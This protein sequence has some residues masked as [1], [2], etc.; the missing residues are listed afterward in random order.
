MPSIPLRTLP[1]LALCLVLSTAPAVADGPSRRPFAKP[2][3]PRQTERIRSFDVQHIKGELALDP[4]KSEVRGTVT[5]TIAP[6]E[7]ALKTLRLDCGPRLVVEKV[8]VDGSDCKFEHKKNDLTITLGRPR[9]PGEAMKVAVTYKGSPRRGMYFVP[10]D[11]D[12]GLCVW[13]QGEPD[14]NRDWLPSYDYPNDRATSEMIVTAPKPLTVVSNGALVA[15]VEDGRTTTFHW[16]MDVPHPSY[17]ISLA[18]SDFAVYRD[19]YKTLPVEYY[20]A[21]TVDEAT[22]RRTLGKTPAMIAFFGAKLGVPYPYP[23]YAQVAV[24]EFTW[25]GMENISA[26]TLNDGA[27]F[28]AVEAR[29]RD[30][31]GLV[32]HELAHQWFGDLVTCKDWSHIW[33]NE[34]FATFFDAVYTE[35]DLGDDAYRL[36]LDGDRRGYI[37]SDRAYRRPIVEERYDDPLKLFD[38]VTYPKGACVLHMLRGLLGEDAFWAGIRRYLKDNREKVVATDDFHKAMEAA[39]GKDLDWYFDQWTKKAG[40]PELKARWRYESDDQ[41]VRVVVEQVQTLDDQTPLFR[42]PTTLELTDDD[43]AKSIPVVVD[44]AKEEFVIPA[45]KR[46]KLVRLDPKGWLLKTLDFERPVEEWVYQLEHAPEVLGRVEAAAALSKHKHDEAARKALLAAWSRESYHG[47][48]RMVLDSL[49]K[50][51]EPARPALLEAARDKDAR[52][53]SEAIA[54]LG[55]LKRDDAAEATLRAAWS[56]AEEAYGVRSAALRGLVKWGVKD[57]DDLLSA[58]LKTAAH[59]DTIAATALELLLD[60]SGPKARELAV[61]YSRPGHGAGLR[62]V[63]LNALDRLGADDAEIQDALIDLANDPSRNLR[64]RTWDILA[65][66]KV[67]RAIPVLEARLALEQEVVRD[68]L[69][70]AIATLKGTPKSPSES[71]ADDSRTIA[72]LD[73]QAAEAEVKAKELRLKADELRLKAEKAKLEAGRTK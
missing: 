49:A 62:F 16:K 35:H 55:E 23:K 2:G 19:S 36:K 8:T 54:R 34:G 13:T 63:A 60:E 64:S 21:R 12:H 65:R 58:G 11:A 22:A 44:G 28:D 37:A 72:D 32:A 7:P 48:R 39:S 24:P 66:S 67:R 57:K 26:T 46:P 29:E 38:G 4:D 61:R 5:H 71:A 50:F 43:G 47:A 17:L 59:R 45:A 33:L 56:D 25:G 6:L 40:H 41:T 52:V 27:F 69:D 31:D 51:G 15:T 3:T 30:A 42:L 10:A 14:E 53:R 68:R 70:E 73:R 1:T 20:V 18:A 9:E